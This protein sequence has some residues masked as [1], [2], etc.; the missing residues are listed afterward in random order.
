MHQLR[1]R[2][3]VFIIL[4][5]L[6]RVIICVAYAICS[7]NWSGII[8][9]KLNLTQWVPSIKVG[10]KILLLIHIIFIF[11][12][13]KTFS[14]LRCKELLLLFFDITITLHLIVWLFQRL[15]SI[16]NCLKIC[17][18]LA[19]ISN[20]ISRHS[21]IWLLLLEV[22]HVSSINHVLTYLLLMIKIHLIYLKVLLG[23][24]HFR[25][26]IQIIHIIRV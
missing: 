26:L 25:F 6:Y 22:L 9:T 11:I 18:H 23:L 17:F 21:T 12:Y 24:L 2:H 16:L 3:S 15:W 8:I 7:K 13:I 1:T 19:Q 10:C 5:C 20:G 14:W 4:K